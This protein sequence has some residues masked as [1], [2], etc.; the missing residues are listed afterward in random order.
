ML[1]KV[2][3]DVDN[4]AVEMMNVINRLHETN[5]LCEKKKINDFIGIIDYSVVFLFEEKNI[6]IETL[7]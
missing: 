3:D 7:P 4:V 1:E 5:E 2:Y 6:V